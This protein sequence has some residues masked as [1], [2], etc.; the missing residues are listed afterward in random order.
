[1]VTLP[2]LEAED[3]PLLW[4]VAYIHQHE[5]EG[6]QLATSCVHEWHARVAGPDK[7]ALSKIP[8]ALEDGGAPS[9]R[10]VRSPWS[11]LRHDGR[12]VCHSVPLVLLGHHV[13]HP[14]ADRIQLV[15]CLGKIQTLTKHRSEKNI[16]RSAKESVSSCE[17]R[18]DGV[19]SGNGSDR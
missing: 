6:E 7:G 17:Q 4:L 5:R 16:W 14:D 8:D 19:Q 11:L 12:H 9:A 15:G 18:L 1:M 2:R 10:P 3:S 13:H